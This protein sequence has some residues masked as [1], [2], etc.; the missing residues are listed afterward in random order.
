MIRPENDIL[1]FTLI[2]LSL[3]GCATT[4]DPYQTVP[5]AIKSPAVIHEP[6]HVHNYGRAPF[7]WPV[8]GSIINYYGGKANRVISKGI[9]IKAPEGTY[10][11]ASKKG[12]VVFCDPNF[13]GYGNTIIID[14][15][16]GYET[17]YAYNAENMVKTGD[18]VNQNAVIAKVG[19]TGR[20]QE[21]SLHFEI[22]SD[23]RSQN[24][25]N[26]LSQ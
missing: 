22:R 16:D 24:P 1:I 8:R 3:C 15:G 21:P 14:H 19:R 4:P 9:D 17:V 5:P 10:V 13:K 25:L 20:A 23:G 26:Y 6:A 12:K 11:R 2:L 18:V 7:V